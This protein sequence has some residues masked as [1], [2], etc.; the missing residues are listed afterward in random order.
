[1]N[2]YH[3]LP[4]CGSSVTIGT[5]L[6]NAGIRF[7]HLHGHHSLPVLGRP[8]HMPSNHTLLPCTLGFLAVV[9]AKA[10]PSAV[11]TVLS[12]CAK[13]TDPPVFKLDM[14]RCGTTGHTNA[15]AIRFGAGKCARAFFFF[16]VAFQSGSLAP[17]T[18][19]R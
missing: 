11:H 17:I 4:E 14:S 6:G 2:V 8:A 10:A 9:S 16:F 13:N 19:C 3:S 7:L 15:A 5:R 12:L 1:M 18:L